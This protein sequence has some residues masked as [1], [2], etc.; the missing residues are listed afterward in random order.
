MMYAV[1][2][3]GGKQYRVK[4]GDYLS[5]E[6]LAGEVGE[7]LTFNDVLAVG[8]GEALKLGAPLLEGASVTATIIQQA[9]AKKIIVFKFKRRK[10]YKRTRGHRQYFTRLKIA[11]IAA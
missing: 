10:N 2:R 7:T 8:E 5:V 1:I 6:R 11:E 9:R 4:Q 3:T